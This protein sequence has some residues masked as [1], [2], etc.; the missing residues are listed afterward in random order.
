M[1][2]FT[3]VVVLLALV[4]VLAAGCGTKEPA[5]PD[6]GEP[7]P[8]VAT[9]IGSDS[10]KGC[11]S[12]EYGDWEQSWHTVKATEGPSFGQQN[13]NNIYEWVR[14]DWDNLTTYMIVDEFDKNTVYVSTEKSALED[15]A[16]VVGQIRKQRYAVYYD[17]GAME[18]YKAT[19]EDGGISW[20]LNTEETFQFEGNKERAGYNFLFIEAKPDGT[21]NNNKYGEFRS[22]QERCI[23]CH[24]TGFD[25]DAWDNAKAEFVAG[26]REDLKEIFVA[27]LRVGCEACHGPGSEHKAAPGKGNITNPATF[28]N[29]EDRMMTCEQCHDRNSK[30]THS[31]TANDARGFIVGDNLN[32]FRVQISPSWGAGSRNVSI[33]GKGR[34][35]HQMNMDMRLSR[36]I[37][38]NSYHA[39]QIGRASCRER[40]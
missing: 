33:D 8:E 11:H 10:C 9:F 38:P 30:S 29:Y 31:D 16:Y 18:V 34:R 32:D 23:S 5:E 36:Y 28:E 6:N 37:N 14:N 3:L 2:R 1:K 21:E 15:V 26:T 20:T 12:K 22:W 40:V 39:D 24:T 35:D 27:D 4:L 7:T 19:T 17:G 13:E 25:R